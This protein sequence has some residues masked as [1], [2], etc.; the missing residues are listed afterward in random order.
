MRFARSGSARSENSTVVRSLA[1]SRTAVRIARAALQTAYLVS[2]EL[3]TGLA[4][5]WFTTPRRHQRPVRERGVLARAHRFSF[6]VTLSAP[7]H[8]GRTHRLAAWRWGI[9]PTVLL[10]HGWEGR[11]SQLGAFV[12]PLVAAGMSVVT[13]DAPGHG[14]SPDDRLYLTDHADCVRAA[15]SAVGPVY[16]VVA[17]SF[18]AA[19]VL[20]AYA[21][22][23][24]EPAR[25]VL[26]SPNAVIED[27][28]ARFGD[29][30]GLDRE[31]L[32]RLEHQIG[33]HAGAPLDSLALDR[34]VAG[35]EGAL[36]VI[37]D[38]D[39]REVPSSHGERLAAVWPNATLLSTSGLGHRK[40]LRDP[41]VLARAT[42]HVAHGI[43]P[44]RSDLVREVDRSLDDPA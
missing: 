10:V 23:A 15:I 14:N 35:R 16:A 13:F 26:I 6:D 20:V 25:T 34:L 5:R 7:F 40:I 36:L 39:D 44:A 21:R 33:E 9:G 41:H 29:V 42:A 12:D 37:H 31:D 22:G 4:E 8:R 32:R 18:G 43:P 1:R 3:G 38:R 11:G 17:H 24:V 2:E 27:A 30:V 19:A 28:I